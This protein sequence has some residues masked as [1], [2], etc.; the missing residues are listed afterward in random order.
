MDTTLEHRLKRLLL[1]RVVMITTLLLIA[2][3]V[4]MVSETLLRVNPLYFLIV[5]TYVLTLLH[6]VSLRLIPFV[7][8]AH[9][10]DTKAPLKTMTAMARIVHETPNFSI[11][12]G[13]RK[14]PKPAPMRLTAAA[15]PVPRQR[16]SVGNTSPG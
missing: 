3:Y 11:V 16:T 15:K 1:F 7:S 6:I 13:N 12:I 4:E 8:G 14:V 9:S 2:V 10:C 5:A